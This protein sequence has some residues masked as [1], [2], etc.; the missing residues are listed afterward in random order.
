MEKE[1]PTIY[2]QTKYG[3]VPPVYKSIYTSPRLKEY[4]NLYAV[5]RTLDEAAKDFARLRLGVSEARVTSKRT[6]DNPIPGMTNVYLK[7]HIGCIEIANADI[8]VHFNKKGWLIAYSSNAY[9]QNARSVFWHQRLSVQE[10]I[11]QQRRGLFTFFNYLGSLID[12]RSIGF[13]RQKRAGGAAAFLVTGLEHLSKSVRSRQ[14]YIQSDDG[15]LQ[16]AWEFIVDRGSNYFTAHMSLD[17]AHILSLTDDIESATYRAVPVGYSNVA[18]AGILGTV[19]DAE[20]KDASPEGWHSSL[21][22]HRGR[23]D[24]NNVRS[25]IDTDGKK[26]QEEVQPVATDYYFESPYVPNGAL[27]V[28]AKAAMINVFQVLNMCHDIFYRFGFNEKAGNFQ[29]DNFG[30]G[31]RDVDPVD[32][33]IHDRAM[34]EN[35]YF[36]AGRDG[37]GGILKLGVWYKRRIIS[38]LGIVEA[39]VYDPSF[40]NDVIIHEVTHGLSMR[41]VGGADN[42]YCLKTDEARGMGEGWSD[43][44]AIWMRMNDDDRDDKKFKLGE[45]VTQG[46]GLR[47]Y[48][49]GLDKKKFRMS[50][51]SIHSTLWGWMEQHDSGTLWANILY[52]MYRNIFNAMGGKKSFTYD[53]KNPKLR[54]IKEHFLAHSNTYVMQIIVDSMQLMPCNPTFISGRDALIDADAERTGG[55]YM[56]EIYAAFAKW[57]V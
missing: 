40:D 49:F 35:A 4:R 26:E 29:H 14:T 47:K 37:L 43:F 50:Y 55:K 10:M 48:P 57:G 8:A 23:L 30:R 32:V 3:A 9:K 42:P 18:A 41:L 20:M 12:T 56:C 21:P 5:A 25:F 39:K 52:Q 17:G 31:G 13:T 22:I 51:K 16:P 1:L 44:V 28:N 36:R 45:Y 11:M 24:G 38:K 19:R 53:Y 46:A 33:T 54:N 2:V 27:E 15:V 34:G 7:Q 6:L